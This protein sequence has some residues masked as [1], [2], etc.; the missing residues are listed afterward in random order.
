MSVRKGERM[1][2]VAVYA[3]LAFLLA[4]DPAGEAWRERAHKLGLPSELPWLRVR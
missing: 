4:D 1:V 2:R 3:A